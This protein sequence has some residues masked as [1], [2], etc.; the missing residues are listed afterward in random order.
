MD[1]NHPQTPGQKIAIV[2]LA[3]LAFAASG[4]VFYSY[5]T[6]GEA[7]VTNYFIM[8]IGAGVVILCLAA[9]YW[10]AKN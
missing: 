9:A 5:V 6:F 8:E 4:S 10:I 3:I 1:S 7:F 2:I